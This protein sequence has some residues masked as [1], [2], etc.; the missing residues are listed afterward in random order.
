MNPRPAGPFGLETAVGLARQGISFRIVDK[1]E[2]ALLSGRADGL[3]PRSC[4]YLQ[5][6]GLVKEAVNEGPN[7]NTSVVFR[8]GVKLGHGTNASCGD[9]YSGV[10]IITQGQL[11]KVYIRDLLRHKKVVERATTIE[12]F[13]VGD[14]EVSTYPV[15]AT[16]RNV[17]SGEVEVVRAKY[18][19]GADG[20]GSTI[21][22]QLNIPFDGLATD[23]YWNIMDCQFKTDYPHILGFG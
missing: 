12:Q 22:E 1:A 7:I 8:N 18:L 21:R 19:V 20:A 17:K 4:E 14:G 9:R 13:E 2:T 5:S 11:E 16:L 23:C 6:W 15:A 10:N 3:Q